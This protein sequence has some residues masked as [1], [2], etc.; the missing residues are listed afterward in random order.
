M[1]TSVKEVRGPKKKPEK[2]SR[3]GANQTITKMQQQLEVMKKLTSKAANKIDRRKKGRK[4]SNN[5]T[6]NISLLK[7]KMNIKRKLIN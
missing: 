5:E 3:N 6:E 7:R 1:A 2:A 4:E